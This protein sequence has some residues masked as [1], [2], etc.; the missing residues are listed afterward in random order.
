MSRS[1]LAARRAPV[2]VATLVAFSCVAAGC[3][4]PV[5]SSPTALSKSGVPFDLLAPSSPTSTTTSLPPTTVGVQIFLVS[6]AGQLVAADRPV[7]YPAS[8]SSAMAALI[9]GP[10]NGESAAG[11][12]S[13]VPAQTDL[14]S[15]TISGGIAT[16]DLGGTFGQLVGQAQIDAVAQIVFTATALPGVNDVVFELN[17]QPVAVPT[18]S[19][20]DVPT[21]NRSQFRSMAPS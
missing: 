11:L 17:G 10:T 16:V 2:L 6:P 9:D 15:A 8:L 3:G 5:D 1:T 18:A 14:L 7:P 20:A 19:G 12:Q 13:A 21:A 4:V